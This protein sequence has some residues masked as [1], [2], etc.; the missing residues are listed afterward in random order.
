M[1]ELKLGLNDKLLFEVG[2]SVRL[3]DYSV[4]LVLQLPGHWTTRGQGKVRRDG[5][6]IVTP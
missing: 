1:P 4:L 6:N 3:H 5:G 2:G